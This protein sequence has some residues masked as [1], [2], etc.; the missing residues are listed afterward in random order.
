ECIIASNLLYVLYDLGVT[1]SFI[2]YDYVNGKCFPTCLLSFD[3]LVSMPTATL[4]FQTLIIIDGH[5]Y[6][7]D[8]ICPPWSYLDVILG[9]DWLSSYHILIDCARKA[10]ILPNLKDT[11]F[12]ITNQTKTALEEGA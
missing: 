5:S 9:M 2:S 6:K 7:A 3:V 8:L 4:C 1:Y 11:G 12:I 10:L